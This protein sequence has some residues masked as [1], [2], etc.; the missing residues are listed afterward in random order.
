MGESSIGKSI[1]GL[2]DLLLRTDT[3]VWEN[4]SRKSAGR[5]GDRAEYIINYYHINGVNDTMVCLGPYDTNK[6]NS[7]ND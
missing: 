6:M 2:I 1:G 7:L 5:L 4:D 3:C